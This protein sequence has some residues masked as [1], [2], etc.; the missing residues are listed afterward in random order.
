M[1]LQGFVV[2]RTA[3][4]VSVTPGGAL[5]YTFRRNGRA[6]GP[7]VEVAVDYAHGFTFGASGEPVPAQVTVFPRRLCPLKLVGLVA[8][9]AVA[10]EAAK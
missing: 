10:E 6:L 4:T 5:T 2:S 1:D 9:R 7:C 8:A 3:D